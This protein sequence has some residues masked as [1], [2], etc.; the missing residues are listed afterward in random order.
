[1]QPGKKSKYAGVPGRIVAARPIHRI[2]PDLLEMIDRRVSE[3][4]FRDRE[5]FIAQAVRRMASSL[6]LADIQR[7]VGTDAPLTPKDRHR[8]VRLV[9][10]VRG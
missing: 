3:G 4:E 10:R 9:R 1:M 5:E 6:L 8:I 7:R 2:P